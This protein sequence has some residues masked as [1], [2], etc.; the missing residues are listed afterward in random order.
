MTSRNLN[1]V[2]NEHAGAYST[3]LAGEELSPD[4]YDALYEYYQDEIPYGTAK[5]RTGDP[6]AWIERQL[7]VHSDV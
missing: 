1:D 2:L 7:E 3:W 5:A 6:R 4:L